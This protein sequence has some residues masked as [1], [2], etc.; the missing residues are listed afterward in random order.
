MPDYGR[1]QFVLVEVATGVAT[2]TLNRPEQLNAVNPQL[3]LEL[4][5]VLVEVSDDPDVRAVVITG[6]G[7]A[8]CAGGDINAM[9]EDEKFL[10]PSWVMDGPRRLIH[11]LVNVKQPVICAL[12]G[13]AVGVGATIALYCDMVI[14]SESARIGD[15]HVKVGLVAGD[16]GAAIWPLLTSLVKAKELLMTGDLV[17]ARE[18]ERIGL[19]NRVV[20][21]GKALETS[22]E[23]AQRL[24]DGA[25]LAIQWTKLAINKVVSHSLN[26]VFD[27]SLALEGITAATRDHKEG[28]QAFLEKRSPEFRGE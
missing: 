7:R 1:Y 19:V 15:P 11:N 20:P 16:G 6:A 10:K 9:K 21:E 18:A 25:S 27:T 8:F 2:L 23:L 17:D 3:H 12:N 22:L 24:A 28:V 13:A 14:A 26:M 5:E 4:E